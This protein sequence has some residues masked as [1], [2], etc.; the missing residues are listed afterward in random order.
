ME[1]P[2]Q[3]ASFEEALAELE[4]LAQ[5]MEQRDLSLEDAIA[6]FERGIALSRFCKTRLGEAEGKI[7]QLTKDNNL[8]DFLKPEE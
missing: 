5:E 1:E 4:K 3:P 6:K 2:Q 8:E 7:L